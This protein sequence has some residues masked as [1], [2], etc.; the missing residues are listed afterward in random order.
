MSAPKI[1]VYAD[2]GPAS[3]D[4][5]YDSTK[6]AGWTTII[7]GLL[8]IGYPPDWVE[9]EIFFNDPPSIIKDGAY[10]ADPAWP[11]KIAQL[12]QNS[13]ITQIY[14]S[15]GGG[16]PV[17]DFKTIKTI[18]EKN[19]NS[20][21]GTMLQRNLQ[22][23]RKTFPAIDGIDMDCE[24]TYDQPSFVAFCQMLI[25]MGFSIT[26]CSAFYSD[27]YI[28]FWV[29]SLSEIEKSHKGAVKWWNLQC[30]A[31]G[32]GNDPQT[33]ANAIAARI[34]GF[35][36]EKF[37]LASD[38]ARFYD[39]TSRVWGGHCPPAVKQQ[40]SQF[41]K[42]ACFGGAFIWN[43]ASIVDTQKRD[44]GQCM[45]KDGWPVGMTDYVQA[46]Q[47]AVQPVVPS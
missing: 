31:G 32:S 47:E 18:Y 20:F 15:F 11:A 6:K 26:F 27:F 33:W 41:C 22:V 19:N 37:I 17:V 9:A 46:I 28:N 8:H 39:P 34:P 40:I 38:W 29:G 2:L 25:G 16:D 5:L 21:N 10:R 35:S 36:A 12:K 13:P 1:A 45:N 43:M 24:E 42:E 14:A 7:L 44:P 3:V 30:Y 23:F 4:P